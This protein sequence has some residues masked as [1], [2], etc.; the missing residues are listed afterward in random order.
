MPISLLL[1]NQYTYRSGDLYLLRS[2]SK[3]YIDCLVQWGR[4]Q[5]IACHPREYS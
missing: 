4:G 3:G 1:L 5:H 2:L